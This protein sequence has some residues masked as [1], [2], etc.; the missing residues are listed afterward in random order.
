MTIDLN[1]KEYLPLH[2][3]SGNQADRVRI[4]VCGGCC[5]STSK[6]MADDCHQES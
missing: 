4:F 1:W 2:W 5:E 6:I 3:L